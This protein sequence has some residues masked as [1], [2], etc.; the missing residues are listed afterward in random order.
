MEDIKPW[1]QSKTIWSSIV[2]AAAT[3]AA[4]IFHKSVSVADQAVIVDVVLALISGV[5]M[6]IA[7]YGR[8]VAKAQIGGSK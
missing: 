5:G 8:T 7:I 6:L 2:G 4:L 1:W 3:F